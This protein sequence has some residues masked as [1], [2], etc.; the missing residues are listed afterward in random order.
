MD[1][2]MVQVCDTIESVYD[3]DDDDTPSLVDSDTESVNEDEVDADA[4]AVIESL[5]KPEPQT[6]TTVAPPPL[7]DNE[8]FD[9]LFG[10]DS[11]EFDN[12]ALVTALQEIG[13]QEE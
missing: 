9:A 7:T 11:D 3:E 4:P 2:Q 8:A 6:T 10:S 5:L 1:A 12:E 13:G